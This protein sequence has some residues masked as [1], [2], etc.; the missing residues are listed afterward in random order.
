MP[1]TFLRAIF[2]LVGKKSRYH[3]VVEIG[4]G[5][6]TQSEAGVWDEIKDWLIMDQIIPENIDPPRHL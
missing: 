1:S 6:N 5:A 2:D 4:L 3:D